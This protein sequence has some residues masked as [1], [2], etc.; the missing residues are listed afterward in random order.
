MNYKILLAL[1]PLAI[2]TSA[3]AQTYPVNPISITVPFTPGGGTDSMTR[4]VS[5]HLANATNWNVIAENRAGAAGTIGLATV[6]RAAPDGYNLV[7]GQVDNLAVA[8][9]L[10][11]N[12]SYDSL[13]D[14]AP[15]INVA[16]TT[17]I[18]ATTADSPYKTLEDL[19][20]AAKREPNKI[21]YASPGAGTITHL[22][23][24]LFQE[25]AG[26]SLQHIPYKGSSPAMADL[27]GG[28]VPI[29]FTSVPSAF[30]QLQAGAIRGLAVTSKARSPILPEVPTIAEHGY[31]DFDVT[32]WYGL[33]APA[34]TP[35][36]VLQ[37]INTEMNKTLSSE[38]VKQAM[39][40][41]GAEPLG[42]T[43]QEF[44]QTIENDYKKWEPIVKASAA[45]SK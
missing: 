21:D 17:V 38:S 28:Q 5:Q 44:A 42:G 31:K 30:P 1:V 14:F 13:K 37:Q 11:P 41:Q 43:A 6:A 22:A 35:P 33:L 3:V 20:E 15:I 16:G 8:P 45:E 39:Y 34:G 2:A 40:A 36:A 12:L 32:V 7:M 29:L 18:K 24:V 10:Y 26:I 25:E 4:L 9:W 19:I 23:A 27:L